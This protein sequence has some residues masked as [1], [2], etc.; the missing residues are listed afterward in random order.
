MT[1][2]VASSAINEALPEILAL[3]DEGQCLDAWTIA[4]RFG[5]ID[6]WPSVEAKIVGGRLVRHLGAPRLSSLLH[7]RCFRAHRENA[8]AQYYHLYRVHERRGALVAW[9]ERQR[10]GAPPGDDPEA[11]ADYHGQCAQLLGALRD[12]ERAEQQLA[13]SRAAREARPYWYVERTSLSLLQDK[14]L[15]GLNWAQEGL[16]RYRRYPPLI[17]FPADCLQLLGR[18]D[19]AL[20]VLRTALQESQSS[21]VIGYLIRLLMQRRLFDEVPSALS[22]FEELAPLIEPEGKKWL[23]S[24]RADVAMYRGDY[25]KAMEYIE[26]LDNPYH[27]RIGENLRAFLDDPQR[28]TPRHVEMPVPFVRQHHMTCAPATLTAISQFWN[29]PAE[30]LSVAEE[31]CYDGTPDYSER[32]WANTNG[33]KTKEF[34]VDWS[35]ARAV[36]DRGIPFTLTTSDVAAGH[37]Q[38]AIGYDEPTRVLLVRDPTVHDTLEINVHDYLENQAS[39]G[40][41]GMAMVP[42][43][44]ASVLDELDLPDS[45][46][47]DLYHEVQVALDRHDRA[48]AAEWHQRMVAKHPTHRLT[49]TARRAIAGYD[50]NAREDLAATDALLALFPNDQ[51]LV[52][53]RLKCLRQISTRAER[54]AWLET[55]AA[56]PLSDA[57]LWLEYAIELRADDRC[58]PAALD[59]IRRAMRRRP[60]NPD[61]IRLLADTYW[62]LGRHVDAT[63]LYR[64]AACLSPMREDFAQAY[65]AA[66]RWLRQPETGL[67]FLRAR[68]EQMGAQSGHPSMSLFNA[69]EDLERGDEAFTTLEAAIERRQDDGPLRLFAAMK[70]A[71]YGR[72][73]AARFHLEAARGA[74]KHVAWLAEAAREARLRGDHEEALGRWRE[75]LE[76]RPLDLEAHRMTALLLSSTATR[77]AA[78]EHLQNYCSAFP[79]HAGLQRLLYHWRANDPAAMREAVLRKMIDIDRADAWAVRELAVNLTHQ[80]RFDEALASS[81]EAIAL[82]AHHPAGHAVKGHVLKAVGRFTEAAECYRAAVTSAAAATDAIQGLLD[83]SGEKLQDRIAA[84]EF[85]Q[86]QLASQ[87]MVGDGVLSFRALARGVLTPAELLA[88]LRRLSEQRPDLWQADAALVRHLTEMGGENVDEALAI[89]R[90]LTERLSTTAAVWFELSLVH[91][92]RLEPEDEIAALARCRDLS[93]E[94]IEPIQHMADALERAG[95]P[96]ETRQ[97]FEAA[98]KRAPLAPEL[99]IRLAML[100]HREGEKDRAIETVRHTLLVNPDFDWAW[101]VLADWSNAG[102]RDAIEQTL[103]FARAFTE[104]RPREVSAWLR[105]AELALRV[106]QPEEALAAVEEAIAVNPQHVESHDVHAIVLT[107]LRRFRA[108]EEACHPAILAERAPSMLEG[109]AAWVDAQRGDMRH[110]IERMHA[111]VEHARDYTWGWSQLVEWHAA[112]NQLKQA[113]DAAER[114]AWLAPTYIVPLGW[115]GDLKQRAGDVAGAKKV[116]QRAMRLEPDYLF[117]GMRFFGIQKDERSFEDAARTL[118]I[119]RPYLR[120]EDLEVALIELDAAQSKLDSTL[121]RI[122]ALCRSPAVDVTALANAID[123]VVRPSWFKP[124]E[125]AIR[126]VLGEG[127]SNSGTPWVWARVRIKRNRLGGLRAYRGLVG[128]GD[129]GKNAM[130]ALITAIGERA[131]KRGVSLFARWYLDWHIALIVLC[132]REWRNDDELWGKIGYALLCRNRQHF[133]SLWMRNW[134]RRPGAESWMLQNLTLALLGLG[135]DR[136]ALA[137]LRHIVSTFSAKADIGYRLKLWGAL[138]VAL[139]NELDVADRLLHETPPDAVPPNDL[140]VRRL[141]AAFV[142]IRRAPARTPLTSEQRQ[143]LEAAAQLPRGTA[144]ARLGAL[145]RYRVAREQG[146]HWK[147]FVAWSDMNPRKMMLLSGI[148]VVVAIRLITMLG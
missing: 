78:I 93:P 35:S 95:R 63:E 9:L 49:H 123:A 53:N 144:G 101:Q 104:S 121:H 129:A 119:L 72:A 60:D 81:N 7:L 100:M 23:I 6:Q 87:P 122:Q 85:V 96:N 30:H 42:L 4:Q 5:P 38:A 54:L 46:Q 16:S 130:Y 108:A 135:R 33:W 21:L 86:A 48:N 138:S 10:F 3:Y 68:Y 43:E 64:F 40:P 97:L 117:A 19:E 105:R 84:L 67:A 47:Y 27:K 124:L 91:R 55:A 11:V 15:D 66:C 99:R 8:T 58:I 102:G 61:A 50:D 1:T 90:R 76:V 110:A 146:E 89:A 14:Y 88:S 18:S 12:F 71:Q 118:E 32:N 131:K 120:G 77:E 113:A 37:L 45:E 114:W 145:V 82:D 109:R 83:V 26:Q 36:I 147:R 75:I 73:D 103:N 140:P 65:C 34:R 127:T 106:N 112:Q 98:I 17:T 59:Q 148:S 25:A 94:W 79:H 116:F 125:R 107:R 70:Y 139:D 143:A 133:V 22:R 136:E 115:L 28:G 44:Q 56:N 2:V 29:R 137:V 31:I 132:S 69:L 57:L 80:A 20:E 39:T 62:Q 41:R 128:K 111:V 24:A 13:L 52:I 126:G 134:R 142:E 51:R 74:V 141:A 92:A